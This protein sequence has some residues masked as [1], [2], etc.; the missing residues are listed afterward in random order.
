MRETEEDL[1]RQHMP[2]VYHLVNRVRLRRQWKACRED[3]VSVA[4]ISLIKAIRSYDP[5]NGA[6]LSSYAYNRI[7]WSILDEIRRWER[8]VRTTS[9]HLP[10]HSDPESEELSSVLTYRR[11]IDPGGDCEKTEETDKA[12][13][14]MRRLTAPEKR[15][16][17][18]AI[19]Q[20]KSLKEIGQIM[21]FTGSRASQIYHRAI[22]KLARYCG[23]ENLDSYHFNKIKSA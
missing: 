22:F 17:E 3:L 12:L 23:N 2:M 7:W 6:K 4:V 9:M 20:E 13:E 10:L 8:Q 11:D 16:L 19:L 5:D 18:L 15:V 1:I 14:A 21:G